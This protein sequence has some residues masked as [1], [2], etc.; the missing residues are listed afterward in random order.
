MYKNL[1]GVK[2]NRGRLDAEIS[3]ET[4]EPVF[5]IVYGAQESIPPGWEAI[6][7]YLKGLQIRALISNGWRFKPSFAKRDKKHTAF[8]TAGSGYSVSFPLGVNNLW[9][10]HKVLATPLINNNL[11]QFVVQGRTK[12]IEQGM[13]GKGEN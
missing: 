5:V 13:R 4:A 9:Q 10:K 12:H 3:S 8:K 6:P 2:Y 7:G 1:L 11:L